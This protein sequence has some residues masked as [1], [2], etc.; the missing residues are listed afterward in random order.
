MAPEKG[1]L[2]YGVPQNAKYPCRIFIYGKE[3]DR[4]YSDESDS[5]IRATFILETYPKL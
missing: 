5:S 3:K 2:Y 4:L 1:L